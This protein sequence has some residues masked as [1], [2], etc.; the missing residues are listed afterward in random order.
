[1]PRSCVTAGPAEFSL[2]LCM[3]VRPIAFACEVSL[4]ED[5]EFEMLY[6]SLGIF[7]IIG[8]WSYLILGLP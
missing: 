6:R 1:M 4:G 7:F 2:L 8:T 3:F 5:A